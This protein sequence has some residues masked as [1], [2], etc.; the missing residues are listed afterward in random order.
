[1]AAVRSGSVGLESVNETLPDPVGL[2][3][4]L[5]IDADAEELLTVPDGENLAAELAVDLCQGGLAQGGQA[6]GTNP[7][8]VAG[9]LGDDHFVNSVADLRWEL[10]E[11]RVTLEVVRK[12]RNGRLSLE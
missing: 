3:V 8:G 12:M 11:W 5:G 1:M 10:E 4:S 6:H 2:E 9:D 7:I